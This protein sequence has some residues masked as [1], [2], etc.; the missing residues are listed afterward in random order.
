MSSEGSNYLWQNK[1]CNAMQVGGIETSMLDD[2]LGSSVRIAWVNTGSGLR[3]KV[4]IDRGLDIV[5]AFYNQHSLVWL[6]HAG[7]IA[8]R[9]DANRGLEWLYSFTGGL[10]TTC[11]LT[12]IGSP[13]SDENEERGLHGRINNIPASV[14]SIIQ[15]DPLAGKL[16]MSITAVVKQSRL[17]GTNLELKRT[18]SSKIGEA[19]VHIHDVVTNRGSLPVPHMLL[20][21]CNFGWPLIDEDVDIIYRGKCKSRGLEMDDELFNSQHNYKKCHKPLEIHKGREACGFVDVEPDSN[22]ICTIGLNNTKLNM[23]LMMKY[24]KKNLPWLCNWQHWGFGD[25]V[26][27]LEPGTNP[28]IGQNKAREI[29]KLIEL[30]PCESRIYDLELTILTDS[31]KIREFLLVAG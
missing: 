9:P 26:C 27:A 6:S 4:V 25:Y 12:H 19:T 31:N 23:A 14:E 7:I 10:L 18:I 8:P 1:I 17:F 28:P 24:N 20:Y 16:N 11:G 30:A 29:G 22:G 3:Y 2:G 5:D 13:E 21:H 15:P